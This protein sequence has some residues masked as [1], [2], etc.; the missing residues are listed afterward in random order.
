MAK[1]SPTDIMRFRQY[2]ADAAQSAEHLSFLFDNLGTSVCLDY[3]VASLAQAEGV[4]WRFAPAGLP[5][6][7][8]DPGHFAQLLGQYMGECAIRQTTARWFQ[9]RDKNPMFG[10]PCL[11]GF[12]GE[13]WDRV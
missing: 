2:V 11:D 1:L 4:F 5:D 3:S 10:Q 8:S 9:S 13:A 7:L 12:G 6:A